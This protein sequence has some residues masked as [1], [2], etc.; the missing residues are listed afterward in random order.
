MKAFNLVYPSS[1]SKGNQSWIFIWK[2]W[3]WSWNSNTSATWYEEL[4]HL[5]KPRSWERLKA[6]GEGH[7]RGWDGWMASLTRWTWVWATS[8]SWWWTGMLGMLQSMELQRAGYDWVTELNWIFCQ[9]NILKLLTNLLLI[10]PQL[11]YRLHYNWAVE[12]L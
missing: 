4:T 3:C 5:K 12:Q 11:L 8:G 6:G 9:S 10:H 7:D 1:L 2:D